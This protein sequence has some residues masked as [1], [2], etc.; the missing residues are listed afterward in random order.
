MSDG[1]TLAPMG[2]PTGTGAPGGSPVPGAANLLALTGTA[3]GTAPGTMTGGALV[4]V[5]DRADNPFRAIGLLLGA[6]RNSIE[7]AKAPGGD[8]RW[9][10]IVRA[11]Q[12]GDPVS[13]NVEPIAK[14]VMLAMAGFS[15][16][17]AY[18]QRFT[19][20]AYDLLEQT[21]G[22]K[23]LVEASADFLREAIS[24]EF[25]NAIQAA[26]GVDPPYGASPLA[27]AK[28]V[29]DTVVTIANKVPEPEDLNVIGRELFGL[30]AI[31][32]L[33]LPA[34]SPLAA[35]STDH[36]DIKAT[37][38]LRLIEWGFANFGTEHYIELFNLGAAAS[39]E[40]RR[41]GS[42]RVAVGVLPVRSLGEYGDAGARE[43]VFQLDFPPDQQG[44][45][46]E[47]NNI[48][49][50][51]GYTTPAITDSRLFDAAMEQRLRMF[52]AVNK[53][54]ITGMLDTAT[55]NQLLHLDHQ[56][57]T[58]KRARPY[59]ASEVPQGFDPTKNPG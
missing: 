35:D 59:R 29:I 9:V 8:P 18:I 12:F 46:V 26:A 30:L 34:G 4:P 56:N 40:I 22:A 13:G 19:L 32:Q 39:I 58:L 45:I 28:P 2:T 49:A 27:G 21:D 7:G 15:K 23:A 38:K 55:V 43:T 1:S 44:D 36:I 33:P 10:R 51:L 54:P 17:I 31:E 37:G 20:T 11:R 50:A 3:P 47:A 52:Q 24:Q 57:K 25:Y 48:L 41:L 5:G 53:I 14:G 42:R 6:V 16:A